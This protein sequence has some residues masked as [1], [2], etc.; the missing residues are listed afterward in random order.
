MA[1]DAAASG[2]GCFF[3]RGVPNGDGLASWRGLMAEKNGAPKAANHYD[4]EVTVTSDLHCRLI[5]IHATAMT[6]SRKRHS[7]FSWRAQWHGVARPDHQPTRVGWRVV[8]L[9]PRVD[10]L[11][12]RVA[13]GSILGF[14]ADVID[15]LIMIMLVGSAAT[16]QTIMAVMIANAEGVFCVYGQ[17][18]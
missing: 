12:P 4:F 14:W 3:F 17:R 15:H 9:W 16:D 2:T 8:A 7:L 13:S 6:L 5:R 11:M 1:Q 18:Q 10:G